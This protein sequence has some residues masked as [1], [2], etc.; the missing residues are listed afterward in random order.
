MDLLS[1]NGNP[2]SQWSQQI[3]INSDTQA[4]PTGISMELLARMVNVSGLNAWINIPHLA[5]NDYITKFATY[6]YA[7]ISANSLIYVEYSN[8][9]WNTMFAQGVYAQTQATVLGLNNSY[10]FYANRSLNVFN[11][12]QSV[13]GNRTSSQLRFV[14]SSQS[15]ST[16]VT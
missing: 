3:S 6:L 10:Q 4:S 1:T 8:E 16:Y 9:V 2:I 15:V 5:S 11:I 13:F 12:F 14:V 7:N